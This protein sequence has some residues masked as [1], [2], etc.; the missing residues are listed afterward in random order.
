MHAHLDHGCSS[1]VAARLG[2]GLAEVH[3]VKGTLSVVDLAGPTSLEHTHRQHRAIAVPAG[4]L[5]DITNQSLVARA[6]G[7][8][9]TSSRQ[10]AATSS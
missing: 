7:I 4:P 10:P 3:L 5:A 1:V 2:Q 6:V 8:L 9:C